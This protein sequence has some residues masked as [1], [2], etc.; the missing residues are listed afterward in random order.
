LGF[1]LE[2]YG[3]LPVDEFSPLKLK[4]VREEI[5]RSERFCRNIINRNVGRILTAISWGVENE[6]V[7]PRTIQRLREVKPLPKGT[8][9]TF[10]HK[11]RR[12]V[13]IDVIRRTLPY[14]PPILRAMVIIQWLTGCRPSEIFSMRVGEIDQ[15][16]EDAPGLWHYKPAHHKME[17]CDN[18]EEEKVI[19][20]GLPEQKL[21]EP[22]LRDKK[23]GRGGIQ[24]SHRSGR[25]ARRKE[26]TGENEAD[27]VTHRTGRR[28]SSKSQTMQ[29]IL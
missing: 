25:T 1:A 15:N 29:R 27:S 4:T 3:H 6:L 5:V 21:L 17:R 19:P 11:K 26:G 13:P 14:L 12:N 10:S 22:Y 9:G 16:P 7:E 23:P 20:L 8:P 18:D 24:S 2:L 28:A